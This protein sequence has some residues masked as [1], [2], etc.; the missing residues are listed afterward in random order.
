[1]V[2]G[3]K[4]YSDILREILIKIKE[5]KGRKG[6]HRCSI[7]VQKLAYKSGWIRKKWELLE[8]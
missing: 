4:I 3:Y 7:H 5:K 6:N 1:M 2:I 8:K